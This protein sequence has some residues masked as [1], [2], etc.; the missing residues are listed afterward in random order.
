MRWQRCGRWHAFRQG[1]RIGIER[2]HRAIARAHEL[3]A[4]FGDR[5]V[6]EIFNVARLLDAPASHQDHAMRELACLLLVVGDHQQRHLA[7]Q[8]AHQVNQQERVVVVE[9]GG[10]L[11]HQHQG[12]LRSS[13]AQDGHGAHLHVR[14]V[15]ERTIQHGFEIGKA[16]VAQILH[17]PLPQLQR[18]EAELLA[19]MIDQ[20]VLHR[21]RKRAHMLLHQRGAMV[22]R[23]RAPHVERLSPGSV[24]WVVN[25]GTRQ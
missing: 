20:C 14:Q 8:L 1:L 19:H 10:G 13:L 6:E 25:V 16:R 3:H 18:R 12:G 23:D 4:S 15:G 2:C 5:C 17:A 11:I 21:S 7:R 24:A 9:I 22:Y